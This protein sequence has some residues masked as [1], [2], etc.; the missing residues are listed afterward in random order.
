MKNKGDF[1][2]EFQ[3]LQDTWDQALKEGIFKTA[4]GPVIP[5]VDNPTS[6]NYGMSSQ[7]AAV[8]SQSEK[9]SDAE[10]WNK[11]FRLSRG[12]QVD[13]S[14]EIIQ[15]EK[16]PNPNPIP[17][18]TR[19]K[20][21]ENLSSHCFDLDDFNKLVKMK[22]DLHALGDKVAAMKGDEQLKKIKSLESQLDELST[23]FSRPDDEKS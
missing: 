21:Q 10:Y 22:E 9:F 14:H 12:E 6:S 1:R 5:P 4:K 11:I 23:S 8:A 19:G 18:W 7:M 15:E 13:G 17:I 2:T 16:S 3:K 20:D